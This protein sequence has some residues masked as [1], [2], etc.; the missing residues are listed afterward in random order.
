MSDTPMTRDELVSELNRFIALYTE[1]ERRRQ[2]HT[3]EL[4]T[5]R[6]QVVAETVERCA[7][8]CERRAEE[9][10]AEH[11]TRDP[12]TNACYY[13]GRMEDVYSSLDEEDDD[14]AA[15]IRAFLPKREGKL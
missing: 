15:A 6:A 12:D 8:V 3:A 9:R 14:C 4:S 2:E 1:S 11:G 5:A 10:F 13:G 7:K